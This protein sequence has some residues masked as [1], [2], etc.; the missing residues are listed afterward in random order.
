MPLIMGILAQAAAA[1]VAAGAYDLLE[2]QT[3][4][5]AVA[6]VTFTG[7]DTLA[8]GY[9]H[10]QLRMTARSTFAVDAVYNADLIFNGDSGSNY[11]F[12]QLLGN[13][14]SVTSTSGT[15][16]SSITL[17]NWIPGSSTTSNAFGGMVMDILDFSSTSKNTTIRTLA[18]ATTSGQSEVVMHSGLYISTDAVTSLAISSSVANLDTGSRFSLYGI[19]AV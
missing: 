7:L 2:T 16:A 19:R 5:T 14:S 10:L 13:G 3:L 15:S 12:H 11:S 9:Q 1:P 4:G 17:P 8:A 6:S 18:G